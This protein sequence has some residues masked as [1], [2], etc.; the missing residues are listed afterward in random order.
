MTDVM[1]RVRAA[2]NHDPE[3]EWQRLEVGAQAR[4]EYLIT[5]AALH[6]YLPPSTLPCRIL[7]AGGGPGRYTI[8]L[9][10]QGYVMT[11]L[12]LSPA[13]LQHAE[14][15]LQVADPVVRTRVEALVEGSITDLSRFPD[16]SFDAVL[17]LGGPL[18]HVVELDDRQRALKELV[19]V[20]R[21][22]APLFISV[23]NRLGAYRSAVQWP[24]C[25]EQFFPHLPQ[26]GLATI[27]PHEAPT[28][29][30]LPEEFVTALADAGLAVIR[31]YGCNGIGA[32]LEEQHVR[33]LMADG[34]RWSEWEA[35]LLATADH[36]AIAGV[37]N[38]ILAVA[39]APIA[40]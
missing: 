9:A 17:C 40:A 32:H 38:H 8:A 23:M 22:G 11:L 37:S 6:R 19:R 31:L 34:E 4:L 30:F 15:Q 35:L 28:Y 24:D 12:D 27:G 16:Q 1:T 2:Y 18:S 25:W 13:L 33:E 7:D 3:H 20:A 5:T 26:T 10:Q 36:P 21:P 39:T 29:F 14:Q